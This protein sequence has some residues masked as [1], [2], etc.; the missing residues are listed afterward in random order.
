MMP[1]WHMPQLMM[2]MMVMLMMKMMADV[3]AS[4]EDDD[5]GDSNEMK[6]NIIYERETAVTD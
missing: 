2:M 5:H 6:N 1:T 4:D 3:D